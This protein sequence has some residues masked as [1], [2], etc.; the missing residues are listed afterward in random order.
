MRHRLK[1]SKSQLLWILLAVVCLLLTWLSVH[2]LGGYKPEQLQALIGRAGVWGPLGYIALY[3]VGTLALLPS[4]PL[5]ISG[6]MLFGPW[7]GILWT[8][9]GAVVAAAI[10]FGFSRTVGRPL[11]EQRLAGRWQMMDAEIHRGG[12]F[13]MFAIRLIPVM[14]YGIVNFVAGLTSIRFQD[15]LIG[16]VLGTVPSVLPFVL[17]GSSSV[18][19]L[20]TGNVLPLLGALGLTGVLLLFSTWLKAKRRIKA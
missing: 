20:S 1:L 5:N 7:W 14:P 11:M 17:V 16:T 12:L 6:G 9:V 15:F 8:S 4:T 3:A 2:A 18:K 13:Y 19:A 10:A